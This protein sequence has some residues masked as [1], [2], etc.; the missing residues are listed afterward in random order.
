METNHYRV[1]SFSVHMT[2]EQYVRWM[3]ASLT[4]SDEN[5]II[6]CVPYTDRGLPCHREI[7]L[8]EACEIQGFDESSDQVPVL[9]S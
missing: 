5:Q 6:V 1:G 7:A 4:E 9:V 8:A 2:K 3:S